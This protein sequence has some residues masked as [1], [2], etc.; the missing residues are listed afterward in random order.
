VLGLAAAACVSVAA[1]LWITARPGTVDEKVAVVEPPGLRGGFTVRA[2]VTDP[3]P[4]EEALQKLYGEPY[5]RDLGGVIWIVAGA[6]GE[7]ADWNGRPVLVKTL[8]SRS[9]NEGGFD[10]HALVTNS[11]AIRDGQVVGEGSDCA[12]CRTLIGAAL[13]ARAGSEWRLI[14]RNDFL[15]ADGEYGAP[16]KITL[17]F[18]E[19]GDVQL[20][21]AAAQN[22]RRSYVVALAEQPSRAPESERHEAPPAAQQ[23]SRRAETTARSEQRG[24]PEPRTRT[25]GPQASGHNPPNG[26]AAHPLAV[27]TPL[28]DG[29]VAAAV[30]GEPV[31]LKEIIAELKSRQ[32]VVRG[33]RRLARRLNEQGL[34]AMRDRRYAEAAEAFRQAKQADGGDPEVRE[35]LGY[36]LLKAGRIREAEA[37]LLSALEIGPERATAWA[38]LGHVFAKQARHDDAVACLVVAHRFAQAPDE[39]LHVYQRYAREDEDPRIRAMMS[40]ALKRLGG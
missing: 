27:A 39:T 24:E 3:F 26:A 13:F 35:N 18:L 32:K 16:P 38:S 8:I 6:P 29:M 37:A 20:K 28:V 36:A 23:T 17:N 21:L 5:N 14:A 19:S 12:A 25:L 11:V 1:A 34:A 31:E 9:F 33:D 30:S 22:R 15:A 2:G 7:L 40:D 10:R 4:A